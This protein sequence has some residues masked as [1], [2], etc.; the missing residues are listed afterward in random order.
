MK[1]ID[2]IERAL[3]AYFALDEA[4][5]RIFTQTVQHVARFV[6]ITGDWGRPLTEE[7]P[8]RGRPAG[9]KNRKP[10]D[11]PST[12]DIELVET[13]FNNNGAATEGL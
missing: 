4:Q 9:S 3:E 13:L 10:A 2:P 8:K 11:D 6:G 5:Q 12:P 7:K 1:R